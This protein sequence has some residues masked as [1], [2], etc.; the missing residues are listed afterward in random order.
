MSEAASEYLSTGPEQLRSPLLVANLLGDLDDLS[1]LLVAEVERQSWLNAFLLAAGMNQILEDHLHGHAILLARVARHLRRVAPRPLGSIAAAAVRSADAA[2][3]AT[4]GLP[5]SERRAAAWQSRVATIVDRLADAVVQPRLGDGQEVAVAA[6]ALARDRERLPSG[7]RRSIVRLPSCF[8][9]FDQQPADLE[10]LTSMF[11]FRWPDRERS[12]AI[13]GVRTSGNYTAPLHAAYLRALGYRNA[14]VLTFRPGQRWRGSEI[15]A[16]S[17][18]MRSGGLAVVTDDAPKTGGSI[19][20]TAVELE[21]MG[22]APQ[23]IVLL[24]QMLEDLPRLPARMQKYPSV[25]L[26]WQQWSVHASLDSHAVRRTLTQLLGP[27]IE[28]R[29]AKRLP[30]VLGG[31]PRGHLHARYRLQLRDRSS[32]R[33]YDS[34][35]HVKGVGLGYFGDHALAVVRSLQEF[36][37][38]IIGLRDGLLYRRWLPQESR[39]RE[40]EPET[41]SQVAGA[42]V[43]YATSR[44]R[45]L[46]AKDDVSLRLTDR[47]AVW[48]RAA[49]LL[50]RAYGPAGQL[51]RPI[52]YPLVK[53]LLR[54][55]RPSV[56]DGSMDVD[57]WFNHGP[58]GLQKIDF[59]ERAFNSLDVYCYDH[60]FDLAGLAPGTADPNLSAAVR[61][62]YTQRTGATIDPERWLLYRLVHVAEQHRH[63][64]THSLAEERELAREMQQYYRGTVFEDLGTEPAG[65][66]CAFDLDWSLETRKLGFPAISPAAA[67]ALRALARHEYRAVIATGRSI[68]Q[69]RERCCAYRLAGG[70]AEYG[71]LTYETR[72]G[73]VRD[74]LTALDRK[75]M[76]R[77][78]HELGDVQG[79]ILD[80]EHRGAVRAYRFDASG[81]RRG[82][83]A[84]A[85]SS[86]LR[87]P[88]LKDQV[89]VIT[90]AYQTDFIVNT[91][92]KAVGLRA[93][94][95]DL[96]VEASADGQK[97]F[98]LAVG[99]GV[100]DLPMFGLATMP[101]APANGDAAVRAAG[102]EV[103]NGTA[104]AGLSQA[105]AR[106]I[107]HTP[108]ACSQCHVTHLSAGSRLLL[109]ALRVQDDRGLG[110][111]VHTL[112]LAN[113]VFRTAL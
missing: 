38:E 70:V 41:L 30:S 110:K 72:T 55:D 23:S 62:A 64:T 105:V 79:T 48:Q 39:L 113:R 29:S 46:P 20:R 19:F 44:A 75:L 10:R 93:L 21:K 32:R 57:S 84:E 60:V 103:L 104:Q 92:N 68:S 95:Q 109:T 98:A 3:W 27:A 88:A 8:R 100:E 26:P 81:R 36:V 63:E 35:I 78:R 34:E 51:M 45:M 61:S 17:A 58:S 96:G 112:R 12:I 43:D 107:G 14:R 111:V 106:L 6:A 66:L 31:N 16:L 101:L 40:I 76:D 74:L 89:R 86:V 22:F 67:F 71:A 4:R 52:S 9:N 33:T 82:L 5:P 1:D 97:P 73:R 15:K 25:L 59:A 50:A 13:V 108:G 80:P 7:L 91:I 90:G 11:R 28:V 18:V 77:V 47:G 99:D 94:A 42:V 69:V 49:D 24:L 54:V 87:T 56:I 65:P 83:G 85:I 37:P 2:L 102:V 53:K